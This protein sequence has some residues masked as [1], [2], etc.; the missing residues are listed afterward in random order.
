M[1]SE[2]VVTKKLYLIMKGWWYTSLSTLPANLIYRDPDGMV[3]QLFLNLLK[4]VIRALIQV[5]FVG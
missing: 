4:R 5:L 1:A 2:F 3:S